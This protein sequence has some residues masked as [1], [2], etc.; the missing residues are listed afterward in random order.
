M[1]N[2][3]T[4]QYIESPPSYTDRLIS[5]IENSGVSADIVNASIALI[6]QFRTQVAEDYKNRQPETKVETDPRKITYGKYN[7]RT[8][9]EVVIFDKPYLVWLARQSFMTK[10]PE[11]LNAIKSLIT[12]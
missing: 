8:I 4:A 7:G 1:S 3:S 5:F 9:D 2:Q 10:N 12:S 11:H 6:R